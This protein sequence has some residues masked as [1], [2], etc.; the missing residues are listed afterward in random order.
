MFEDVEEVEENIMASKG[1]NMQAYLENFH[2]HKQEDCQYVSDS[3]HEDIEYESYLEQQQG[4]REDNKE[5]S[6]SLVP[7]YYDYESDPWESYEGEMEYL[8]V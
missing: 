3:E 5:R 6:F 1:F 2:V 8:N 7:I 4:S